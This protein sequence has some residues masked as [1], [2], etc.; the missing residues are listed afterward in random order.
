VIWKFVLFAWAA[1][2]AT[3]TTDFYGDRFAAW[4]PNDVRA[5]VT[6]AQSCNHFYG[7]EGYDAE[8][9][10]FLARMTRSCS[11]LD[12]RRTKL[13]RRYRS[14]AKIKK[15]ILKAWPE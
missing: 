6:D 13:A 1:G 5:F 15:A 8:R 4:T 12:K 11:K 3:P 2:A 7:E 10:A 14:S 9:R